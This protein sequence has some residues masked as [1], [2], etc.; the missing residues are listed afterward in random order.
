[1][2]L[3]SSQKPH[4]AVVGS[5]DIELSLDL[6]HT[7]S[8]GDSLFSEP[9]S[10]RPGGRAS[11]ICVAL[12]TL[13]A[14]VFLFSCVGLDSYGSRI[15]HELRKSRVNTDFVE[16]T[17]HPTGMVLN[18]KDPDG[19]RIRMIAPGSG[20]AM[21]ENSLVSGKAMIS[22]CQLAVLLADVSE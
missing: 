5:S 17:D 1:M 20:L 10:S 3:V 8:P 11:D 15:L 19:G 7:P 21:G 14:R 9:V 22:S 16:R 6:P 18:M 2:K 4:I 13:G 12:S